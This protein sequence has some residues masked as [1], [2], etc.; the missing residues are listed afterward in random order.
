MFIDFS[1]QKQQTFA[2]HFILFIDF[3]IQVIDFKSSFTGTV[4]GT[5]ID[6]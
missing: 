1:K 6:N 2:K 3:N 5:N 4:I